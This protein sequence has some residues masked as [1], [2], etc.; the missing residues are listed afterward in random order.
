MFF[1]REGVQENLGSSKKMIFLFK[2][3]YLAFGFTTFAEYLTADSV[4]PQIWNNILNELKSAE[5]LKTFKRL[6]K[7]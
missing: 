2:M 6:I 5:N 3:V 7:N 1:I 4:G